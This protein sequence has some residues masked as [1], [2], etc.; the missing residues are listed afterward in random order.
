MDDAPLL[1]AAG[2]DAYLVG[3]V[4]RDELLGRAVLDVDVACREPEAAARAYAGRAGRGG[5]AAVRAPRRLAGR[6]TA[7]GTRSTSRRCAGTIAD[8]LA[9]RD[10]TVNA[11]ARRLGRPTRSIRSAASRISR[12]EDAA[13]RLR[14]ASSARDPLRLLRA[15]RLEDELGL[16]M[17][18]ETEALVR[19]DASLVG[20]A[21]GR[22]DPR[23]APAA[24]GRRLPPAGRAR[25]ARGAG[26]LDAARLDEV[27]PA[28]HPDYVLVVCLGEAVRALPIS[29][30]HEAV[31][32]DAARRRAAG[33]RLAAR[34]P[35]LPPGDGA[36]GAR[37]ARVPAGGRVRR[38]G[39][40]RRAAA[41]PAEPLLR[42]DE[43]GLEPGPEIGRLLELV[44]EERAAGTIST[45][46]EALALVRR[47][48]KA[49]PD[50]SALP[51][52]PRADPAFQ[53]IAKTPGGA[54][55]QACRV[56]PA[57]TSPCSRPAG[58]PRPAASSRRAPL[59]AR[60]A[61]TARRPRDPWWSESGRAVVDE[62]VRPVEQ[63]HLGRAR[64]RRTRR[65][66]PATRRA[67]TG[68]RSPPPRRG[69]TIASN[70]SPA[71]WFEF[72]ATTP[73]RPW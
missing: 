37:G 50:A 27:D 59:R 7:T 24:L 53:P 26:R 1:A 54:R 55:G 73:A 46:E 49:S 66:P 6:A 68:T 44:E 17:D 4:I 25:A 61:A 36:V 72:T 19:R 3:G 5:R 2:E 52:G 42:G 18:A 23:R 43:L 38:C 28:E 14:R 62:P 29:N 47:E 40:A 69:T 20:R 16:R 22:A 39:R 13:R 41:D 15:V 48:L 35:P 45:R 67:G 70:V 65:R 58:S 33:G 32:L 30:E 10:F 31:R 34:D 60:R 56:I 12:R 11:I 9:T 57:P 71:W 51:R 8:D 64:A 63:E 21:G